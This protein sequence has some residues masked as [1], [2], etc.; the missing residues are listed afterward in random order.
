MATA[1]ASSTGVGQKNR[2]NFE[3]GLR[4]AACLS[5]LALLSVGLAGCGSTSKSSSK[6]SSSFIN[7]KS[8][9]SVSEYGVAASP[10]VSASKRPKKGGGRALV[11]KPYR[12]RGKWYTPK[13]DP[14]YDRAGLASWYGPNFT[15]G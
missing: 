2:I 12:V 10:R 13:E 14:D 8:K 11:G 5:I 4:R 6:S 7:T 3:A 9:F 1:R 15:A